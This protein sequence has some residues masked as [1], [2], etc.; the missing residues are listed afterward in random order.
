MKELALALI[1]KCSI[2]YTINLPDTITLGEAYDIWRQ[3]FSSRSTR[4]RD[5]LQW[6]VG[7]QRP[8]RHRIFALKAE[9]AVMV[10]WSAGLV[11]FHKY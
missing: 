5:L 4:S 9:V 3:V 10:H 1:S 6:A 7:L 11:V 2:I 8:Q